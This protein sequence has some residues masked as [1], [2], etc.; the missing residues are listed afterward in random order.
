MLLAVNEKNVLP[1]HAQ[2]THF[3]FPFFLSSQTRRRRSLGIMSVCP[4]TFV[5]YKKQPSFFEEE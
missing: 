1:S 2:N 4:A 5:T 3:F